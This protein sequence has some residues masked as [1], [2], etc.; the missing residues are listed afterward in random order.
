MHWS[1]ARSE[2][3]VALTDVPARALDGTE[4][5]FLTGP[6]RRLE[7]DA[8]ADGVAGLHTRQGIEPRSGVTLT[9][10]SRTAASDRSSRA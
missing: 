7:L 2:C 5:P 3:T 9:S 4:T 1:S 6:W 10:D 8:V